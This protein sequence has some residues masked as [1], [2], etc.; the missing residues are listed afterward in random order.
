MKK[1]LLAVLVTLGGCAMS[2][3][4]VKEYGY[5]FLDVSNASPVAAAGC[6]SRN[7]A[8]LPGSLFTVQQLRPGALELIVNETHDSENALSVW[9][10]HSLS[11]GSRLTVYVSP[12]FIG[13][14]EAHFVAIKGSC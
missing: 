12:R 4:N 6:L 3:K 2:P 9:R 11:H 13:D 5:Q 10:L 7:A 8:N 1:L 14:P